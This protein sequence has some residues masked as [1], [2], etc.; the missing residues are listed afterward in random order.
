MLLNLFL[1]T[2]LTLPVVYAKKKIII[3][4]AGIARVSLVF[5]ALLVDGAL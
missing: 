2:L 4:K 3:I 5:I 1:P